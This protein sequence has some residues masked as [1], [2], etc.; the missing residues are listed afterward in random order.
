M[1]KLRIPPPIYML[2]MAGLMWLLSHFL[3]IAQIVTAPWNQF[4]FLMMFIA[5]FT[6]GVSLIQF[7]RVHTSINPLHPEKANT[8]VVTGMYRLTR[9]PMYLG[10]LLLLIGWAMVLGSASSFIVLPLFVV[11]LTVQQIIPEEEVLEQKFGQQYRDYK[12]SVRRW[13]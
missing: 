7:F 3:P 1:L 13:L 10:L 9:N 6:D 4:G 2:M 11:I 5:L 8:L 12:Q